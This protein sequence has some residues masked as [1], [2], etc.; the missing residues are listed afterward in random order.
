MLDVTLYLNG[1]STEFADTVHALRN[2]NDKGVSE[3]GYDLFADTSLQWT[4]IHFVCLDDTSLGHV[5]T[6]LATIGI[7]FRYTVN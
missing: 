3:V 5:E 2:M 6:Y 4:P 7:P 1:N